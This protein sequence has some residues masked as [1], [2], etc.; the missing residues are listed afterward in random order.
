MA[1]K[2]RLAWPIQILSMRKISAR[3]RSQENQ[4]HRS[5]SS[6]LQARS[7]SSGSTK[8]VPTG[9]QFRQSVLGFMDRKTRQ[10]R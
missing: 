5:S 10:Q 7:G 6:T 9:A 1:G 2:H 8:Y 4:F 3:K